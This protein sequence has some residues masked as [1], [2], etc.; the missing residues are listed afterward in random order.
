MK[1][2]YLI[3]AIAVC[4]SQLSSCRKFSVMEMV[5]DPDGAVKTL[6]SINDTRKTI[7]KASDV[8]ETTGKVIDASEKISEVSKQVD[9]AV[10]Y[11]EVIQ[12]SNSGEND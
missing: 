10:D 7:N 8:I 1:N 11:I 9:N 12:N 5:F 6:E 3:F 2:I 4:V